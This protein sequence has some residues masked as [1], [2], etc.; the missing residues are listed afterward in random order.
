[1]ST[2]V[3]FDYRKESRTY[4]LVPSVGGT[5]LHFAQDG[6]VIRKDGPEALQQGE[7]RARRLREVALAAE[8][9]HNPDLID[10][11]VSTKILKN[12]FNYSTRGSQTMNNAIKEKTVITDPPPSASFGG[13]ATT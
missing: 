7:D 11:G 10:E 8:A 13:M 12:Q 4:R 5:T 2:P 1:M 3:I 9:E 6:V